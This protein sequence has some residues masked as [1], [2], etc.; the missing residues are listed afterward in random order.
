[1]LIETISL[2]LGS[3]LALVL[4]YYY[5]LA[6]A[7]L[8]PSRKSK[9]FASEASCKTRFVVIVPAHNEERFL[10][11]TLRS[12]SELD[13]PHD[14]FRTIVVAH[15]CTDHTEEI[16][17]STPVECWIYSDPSRRGKGHAL[18]WAFARVL[19]LDCAD[20]FVVIDADTVSDSQLLRVLDS[21]FT[22]GSKAVQAYHDVLQPESTPMASLTYLGYVLS[23]HFKY[24]GRVLL[25][26]SAN[27]LGSG[28]A[29]SRHVIEEHGWNALS[30]S[31]DS[32]YQIQLYM[33][34]IKI[35]FASRARVASEI[36]TRMHAYHTQQKRWNVG[37]YRLRRTY[38]PALLGK[39]IRDRDG[40][41]LHLIADLFVPSYTILGGL[42]YTGW[43]AQAL[44][45]PMPGS[46]SILWH[47][48]GVSFSLYVIAGLVVAKASPR[49]C[50][51]LA[52][53]PIFLISRLAIATAGSR[54][55]EPAWTRSERS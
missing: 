6:V 18:Q 46:A 5:V 2:A 30:I 42:V 43:I 12:L 23:R 15:N 24:P 28:M 33:S 8:W 4:I 17:R 48:V 44:I 34:G 52:F 10:G 21:Y 3:A 22:C 41:A 35:E 37:R 31:E 45:A 47:A 1:V 26:S 39:A 11:R 29:F 36:P 40:G 38:V 19:D 49:V 14:H 53:A 20:V 7:S 55:S 32:E 54:G 16:A 50:A 25:G 27:L 9:R 51:N 13:Y